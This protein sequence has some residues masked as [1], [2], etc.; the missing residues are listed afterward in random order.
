[1][2]GAIEKR[3]FFE[4]A[5]RPA[6]FARSFKTGRRSYYFDVRSTQREDLY[7]ILTGVKKR[8]KPD[9]QFRNDK[10]QIYLFK[11]DIDAFMNCLEEVVQ[12]VKTNGRSTRGEPGSNQEKA[13]EDFTDVDFDD[14]ENVGSMKEIKTKD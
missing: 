14:L 10:H 6:I 2:E 7:L 11:E 5:D 13:I 4:K 9:G 8:Y 3:N 1:M 12:Y